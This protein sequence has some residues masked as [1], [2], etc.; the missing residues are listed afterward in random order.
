MLTPARAIGYRTHM[1]KNKNKVGR[2][3]KPDKFTASINF[4]CHPET[5]AQAEK[6]RVSGSF[7]SIGAA[8]RD[9]IDTVARSSEFTPQ[10]HAAKR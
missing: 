7:K 3:H 9:A 1:A 6:I 8:V 2:P 5:V 10:A 4:P